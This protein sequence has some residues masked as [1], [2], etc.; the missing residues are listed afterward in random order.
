MYKLFSRGCISS[1]SFRMT[2][3]PNAFRL[4]I[5]KLLAVASALFEA[6]YIWTDIDILENCI[7]NMLSHLPIL[8]YISFT[9]KRKSISVYVQLHFKLMVVNMSRNDTFRFRSYG[10][11]NL[12]KEF[13]LVS[14]HLF[15]YTRHTNRH[16]SFIS[17][18][19]VPLRIYCWTCI[20][21]QFLHGQKG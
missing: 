3:H 19:L 4:M 1:N 20:N 21:Y 6:S 14:K 8:F 16:C 13:H 12:I 11:C 15:L 9:F 7:T 18:I 17:F 2:K 10:W 5:R